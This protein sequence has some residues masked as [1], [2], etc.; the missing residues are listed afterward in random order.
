MNFWKQLLRRTCKHRFAW[1]RT[2]DDGRYYQ[3]CL[4]CGT[5]YEYDWIEMRRTDRPLANAIR[6]VPTLACPTGR[7]VPARGVR[8]ANL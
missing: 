4:A 1:P 2:D 6:N 5:A 7:S 8:A 3:I